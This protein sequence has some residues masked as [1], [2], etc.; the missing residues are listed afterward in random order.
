MHT[1]RLSHYLLSLIMAGL[2]ITCEE[3]IVDPPPSNII[4]TEVG[5]VTQELTIKDDRG[6][7]TLVFQAGNPIHVKYSVVNSSIDTVLFWRVVDENGMIPTCSVSLIEYD[8][9]D[10]DII[11]PSLPITGVFLLLPDSAWH[12]ETIFINATPGDYELEAE[13]NFSCC[14]VEPEA[15]MVVDVDWDAKISVVD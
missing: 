7:D 6:A 11:G 15:E 9:V 10:F 3:T 8:G 1:V 14:A 12:Y 4:E 5:V 2:F 13:L